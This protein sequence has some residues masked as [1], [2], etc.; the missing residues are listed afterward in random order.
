M[1]INFLNLL[2]FRLENFFIEVQLEQWTSF[3]VPRK[4]FFNAFFVSFF[5]PQ[6]HFLNVSHEKIYDVIVMM[7]VAMEIGS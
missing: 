1:S 2:A 3:E 7:T 5:A 6:F 4:I